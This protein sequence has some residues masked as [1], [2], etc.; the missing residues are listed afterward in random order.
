MAADGLGAADGRGRHIVFDPLRNRHLRI[1]GATAELLSL[2]PQC[3][4]A[5]DLCEAAMARYGAQTNEGAVEALCRFLVANELVVPFTETDWRRLSVTERRGRHGWLGWAIHNYLFIR[6]PL[7]APE[8]Y[9][10][11]LAPMLAPLFSRATAII[12]SLTGVAGLYLVSRQWERF[13]AT[14]PHLFSLEG[15]AIFAVAIGIVKSLHELG[16]AVTAVRYGCRVPSMG[17]CFMVLVP[18]LY[19]DVSDAW[20]LSSRRQRFAI[21]AAGLVVE[22]AIAAMA[23]FLWAFLPEG[24]AKSLAFAL[25]TTSIALSLGL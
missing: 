13:L 25:A 10:K 8:P 15:A 20:R 2:W 22:M 19:T 3:R 21:G 12:I 14:F 11:R 1:D 24:G 18:M 6:I 16:H 9:L 17:V 4:T 5:A 23:L 7:L